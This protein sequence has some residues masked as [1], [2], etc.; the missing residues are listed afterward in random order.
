[1]IKFKMITGIQGYEKGYE[2][3]HGILA[4]EMGYTDEKDEIDDIATHIV[5]VENGKII[6]YGRLYPAGEYAYGIDK[7]C[8]NKA[9]RKQ[10]VADTILRAFEDR[11]VGNMAGIIIVSV[12]SDAVE[13]FL[14]EDYFKTGEEYV[15][16]GITYYKMKKDLT[17]VRGCRGGCRK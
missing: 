16:E 10:Y 12:P 4:D 17:K 11:A 13:F 15:N 1:M 14:H 7:V 9:D 5:G 6:C 8:V 2:F 3:R